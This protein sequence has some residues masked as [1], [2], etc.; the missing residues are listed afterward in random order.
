MGWLQASFMA[1]STSLAETPS[2]TSQAPMF[3]YGLMTRLTMKPGVLGA[4]T[5]VLPMASAN[6][7]VLAKASSEV[8]SPR[9]ISTSFM[10]GAG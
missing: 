2:E 10:T 4:S 5:E 1:V 7:W 3:S 6:S 8:F 9:M